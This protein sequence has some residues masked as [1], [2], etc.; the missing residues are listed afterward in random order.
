MTLKKIGG[1]PFLVNLLSD[2]ILTKIPHEH[3]TIIVVVDCGNFFIVKG[4]T[5]SNSVLDLFEIMTEFNE[6]FKEF[7]G[8]RKLTHTIDLIEYEYKLEPKKSLTHTYYN[9]DLNCSYKHDE[10]LENESNEED[11]VSVSSFP[12]GYS[13]SQGRLMYYYGKKIV[14][15]IPSNYPFSSLSLTLSTQTNQD[16]E[17]DIHVYDESY[18]DEDEILRSAILDVFDFDMGKLEEEI[19]KVDWSTELTNPLSEYD[20]L[21]EKVDGFIII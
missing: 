1:K 15:N 3:N 14:Y 11:L 21:K 6:K 4:K 8:D 20:F 18:K 5:D 12:H 10:N 16:D 2:F 19:K 17:I 7:L 9:S 13:L